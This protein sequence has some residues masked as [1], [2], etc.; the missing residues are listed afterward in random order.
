MIPR[1]L[2]ILMLGALALTQAT[3]ASDFN[4][5]ITGTAS[6]IDGDTI[7]IHGQRIRLYGI[8]A[9][10]SGQSCVRN[11][12][13]YCCGQQAAT[14]LADMIDRASVRCEQRDIDRYQRIVAVCWLGGVDLNSMMVSKGWAIAYRRYTEDYV[15]H[16]A[17]AQTA[18]A[19]MW[20]GSFVEPAKWRR[21]ARLETDEAGP[22]SSCRIKGN[23]NR[24]GERIY[25][26]PGSRYYEQT[27][28]NKSKGERLCL[29]ETSSTPRRFA[30]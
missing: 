30:L 14:A 16:E 12:E 18:K 24:D 8:D 3:P 22:V 11:G 13:Q 25:H 17:V 1:F 4:S 20:A 23:I 26:V 28:I 9:P 7:E 29:A 2:S 10:E 6:V 21:G 5:V 15:N 27:R 19:G